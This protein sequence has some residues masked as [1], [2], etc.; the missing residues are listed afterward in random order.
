MKRLGIKEQRY[1]VEE[2]IKEER[3]F[4][5]SQKDSSNPEIIK[6]VSEAKGRIDALDAVF[7]MLHGNNLFINIMAKT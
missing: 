7:E 5:T 1:L 6:M 4:F 2:A 3:N